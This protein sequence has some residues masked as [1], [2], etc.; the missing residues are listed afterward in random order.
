MVNNRQQLMKKYFLL[1]IALTL[2]ISHAWAYDFSAVAPSG[3]TLYY[4]I[5]DG[6]AEVTYPNSN[7]YYAD[8]IWSGYTKPTGT[9]NIP[10]TVTYNG[11]NYSVTD[12]GYYSFY[13]CS[14]IT[15]VTI[16]NSVTTIGYYTFSGCTGLTSVTIPN[17]VTNIGNLAFADCWGLTSLSIPNSVTTIGAQAFSDCTGLTSVTIGEGVTVMGIG[18]F[19]NCTHLTTLYYNA[20][21]C[22]TMGSS[23]YPVFMSYDYDLAEVSVNS[24]LTNVVIGNNVTSIPDYAFMNCNSLTSV[25]I[26]N[27]VT[28][29]GNMAFYGVGLVNYC[30][31]ASGS[32]WG[33]NMVTCPYEEGDFLFTDATKTVII[34]YVG[35]GSSVT[36]PNSVTTI[37]SDAFHDNSNIT[38]LVIGTAVTIIPENVFNNMP[39]LVSVEFNATNYSRP[40]PLSLFYG[41]PNFTT[42]TFG[43]GV[44]TIPPYMLFNCSSLTSVTIPNSVT[45]IGNCSFSGCSGLTSVAIPNSVI[46][47]GASA[48]SGCSGLTSITIPNSVIAIGASAF[49]DCSGLTSVTIGNSVTTIGGY[50]FYD[51]SGL[52]R[53]N[54]TGNLD[55]W[56]NIDFESYVSNPSFYAHNLNI[57]NR[58]VAGHLEIPSG[59]TTIK[60]FTFI[61]CSAITSVAIPSSVNTIGTGSFELCIGL[62]SVTIPNSV[63]SL[64]MEIFAECTGL[65]SVIIGNSVIRI[66]K[67]TFTACSNLRSVTIGNSVTEIG[68][69]V[70]S[71]CSSLEEMIILATMPPELSNS[72]FD[73]VNRNIPLYVPA[74]SIGAYSSA[75]GWREFYHI[76]PIQN[77]GIESIE[78]NNVRSINGSIIVSGM[79]DLPITIY[80]LAGRMIV[81]EKAIDGKLYPMPHSGVY[82]VQVGYGKS[83]KVIVVK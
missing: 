61:G 69:A 50:A 10:G 41:C 55:G 58:Q 30:G 31:S 32:P 83:Q 52:T 67:Y 35:T 29:I 13:D 19:N 54:Y 63:T 47:I 16:P 37:F 73:G 82:M 27:F 75:E 79:A 26:P 46:T 45:N 11:T 56:L 48:F 36:I 62:T 64:G 25:F 57:N 81:H 44:Q 14:G 68:K 21:N 17:S 66:E 72:T 80:D 15:S 8:E 76:L 42:I 77:N 49:D 23:D 53:V 78:S 34:R 1:L 60:D 9:L 4:N 40:G 59:V 18:L 51:C 70:F 28:T 74:N 24:T 5:V 20:T 33:A 22:T 7:A 43:E 12:I 6:N 65:R 38:H 3:Q 71:E 2:C 39:N